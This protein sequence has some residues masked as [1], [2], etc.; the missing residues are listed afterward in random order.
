MSWFE[1]LARMILGG[2][3]QPYP[4][5]LR[6]PNARQSM[7]VQDITAFPPRPTPHAG[8]F[9][10]MGM[11]HYYDPNWASYRDIGPDRM[12]S[13]FHETLGPAIQDAQGAG[14]EFGVQRSQKG[15]RLD[16]LRE[17]FASIH[18]VWPQQ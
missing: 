18:P 2:G 10:G 8:G 7:N 6:D 12:A 11:G 13:W 15:A 3:P 14:N 16:K 9:M 17:L 1:E 4:E 5:H